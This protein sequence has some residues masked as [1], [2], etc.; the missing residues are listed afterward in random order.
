M[1]IAIPVSSTTPRRSTTRVPVFPLLAVLAV[2]AT[3]TGWRRHYRTKRNLM[4]LSAWQR[5]DC[6]INR[7]DIISACDMEAAARRRIA[8]GMPTDWC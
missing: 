6:G 2:A 5:V 3:V 7:P 8:N 4:T 1:T